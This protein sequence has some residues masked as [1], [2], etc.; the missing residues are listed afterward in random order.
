MAKHDLHNEATA[1]LLTF[2]QPPAA[3]KDEVARQCTENGLV[4]IGVEGP[5]PDDRPV[6]FGAINR[7]ACVA[8][9]QTI[10]LCVFSK[11]FTVDGLVGAFVQ[12]HDRKIVVLFGNLVKAITHL[13]EPRP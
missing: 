8:F 10:T 1:V 11:G 6:D 9:A 7:E 4:A 3:S 12:L 2:A 13:M 5:F